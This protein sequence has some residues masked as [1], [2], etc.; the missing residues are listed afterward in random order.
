[1]APA[2]SELFPAKVSSDPA[3]ALPSNLAT[4]PAVPADPKTWDFETLILAPAKV[5]LFFQTFPKEPGS[6]DLHQVRSVIAPCSLADR[7]QVKVSW[8]QGPHFSVRISLADPGPNLPLGPDNLLWKAA[9]AWWEAWRSEQSDFAPQIDLTLAKNIP[10]AAGLGG[11]SSDAAALLRVLQAQAAHPV[12]EEKMAR[13]ICPALGSDV[14]PAYLGQMLAVGGTGHSIEN[15]YVFPPHFL[16][17]SCLLLTFPD[18][19]FSTPLFYGKLDTLGAPKARDKAGG[20]AEM[21]GAKWAKRAKWAKW[22]KG[23][24]WAMGA[25]GAKGAEGL[26]SNSFGPLALA[27]FPAQAKLIQ[28]L[29]EFTKEEDLVCRSGRDLQHH[30][31]LRSQDLPIQKKAL[32]KSFSLPE[33]TLAQDFW[34]GLWK[35]GDLYVDLSGTGPTMFLLYPPRLDQA[36]IRLATRL[37][38]VAT[39]EEIKMKMHWTK[40]IL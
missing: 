10:W 24:K 21:K 3:S 13:I 27:T 29:F 22:A 40:L 35:E 38:T 12:S 26:F 4:D 34:P 18:I 32:D 25:K 9:S 36:M 5:N 37:Q 1:M 17:P 16:P 11:G 31:L 30:L 28:E 14:Y 23:T 7:I 33:R 2:P 15:L 19:H 8:H 6:K 39:K 20:T